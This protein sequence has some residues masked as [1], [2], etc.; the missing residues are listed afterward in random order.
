MT[1]NYTEDFF[2]TFRGVEPIAPDDKRF[3][4]SKQVVH[5][6]FTFGVLRVLLYN[7]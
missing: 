6:S 2:P 3:V 4:I 5:F 7:Y 1:N